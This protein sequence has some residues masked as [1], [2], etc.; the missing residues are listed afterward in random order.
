[1]A[2]PQKENGH[3]DIANELAEKMAKTNLSP[4]EWR[5]LWAIWRKTYGWHKKIDFISV[6]QL[7]NITGLD[8]RNLSR[9]KKSLLSKKI[10]TLNGIN[11]GFNKD[12]DQWTLSSPKTIA[13][14]VYRDTR[15][16]WF[17]PPGFNFKKSE[18]TLCEYCCNEVS[19]HNNINL[20]HILPRSYGGNNCKENIAGLC[21]TCHSKIHREIGEYF[22]VNI[23]DTQGCY[24]HFVSLLSSRQTT[25]LSSIKTTTKETTTK[26]TITKENNPPTPLLKIELPKWLEPELWDQFKEHRKFIKSKLSLKAE[27]LNL[28]KLIDLH[29]RGHDHKKIIEESI[30]N[31]WKSFYEPKNGNHKLK[32]KFS[33]NTIQT[34]ENLQ[35]FIE[36]GDE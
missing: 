33:P 11:I 12:Y 26:E 13:T 14:I 35:R 5:L 8:R 31:N 23:D 29:N 4:Y 22:T 10:I 6:T 34:M 20:H 28:T 30:A 19:S 1:M 21:L 15:P 18:N 9:T 7:E 25:F 24:R 27:Q 36:R 3:I 2:N 16:K 17:P 32:G